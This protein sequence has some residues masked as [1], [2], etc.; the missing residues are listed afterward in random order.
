MRVR[1]MTARTQGKCEP[2]NGS[3][4]EAKEPCSP[5]VQNGGQN[6]REP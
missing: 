5:V 3:Q 6:R 1:C 4:K 2:R